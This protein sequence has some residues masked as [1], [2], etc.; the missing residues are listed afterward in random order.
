[1]LSLNKIMRDS[2]VV[3]NPP[4]QRADS[5]FSM[6]GNWEVGLMG[7]R[8]FGRNSASVRNVTCFLSKMLGVA[9]FL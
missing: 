1:M 4:V 6:M 7:A 5:R 8:Y 2:S 9:A 3:V